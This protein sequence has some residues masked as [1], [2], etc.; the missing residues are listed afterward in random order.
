MGEKLRRSRI[1]YHRIKIFSLMHH[2]SEFHRNESTCSLRS[3]SQLIEPRVKIVI[4]Y[5]LMIP[6]YLTTTCFPKAKP[7]FGSHPGWGRC[8]I[9]GKFYVMRIDAVL[10]FIGTSVV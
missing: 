1:D 3:L 7:I 4:D 6:V 9:E 2:K 10:I 5:L 8:D